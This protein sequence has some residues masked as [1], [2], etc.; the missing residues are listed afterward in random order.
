VPSRGTINL[1][2][3]API[4]ELTVVKYRIYRALGSELAAPLTQFE[5]VAPTTSFTDTFSLQN[6]RTY[7]YVV[8]AIFG[9]PGTET[10]SGPSNTFTVLNR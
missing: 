1:V 10:F 4:T 2:W 5:V 8:I 6:N 9:S 3:E 7:T